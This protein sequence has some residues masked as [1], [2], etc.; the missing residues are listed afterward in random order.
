MKLVIATKN[1]NKIAEIQDKF[2]GIPGLEMIPLT[3]FPDPP[4]VAEDGATFAENAI[5]K[6]LAAA[7][8]T[9]HAAMADDSGLV[10]DALDG[11]PGVL[12]ARYGGEGA[13]DAER[14]RKILVEMAEIQEGER[15][16]RF[17]CVIAIAFPGGVAW[18]AE[19]VCEGM[20]ARRMR[21]EHGFGYDPIFYLPDRGRTM[22]E[23]P[24]DEK[25]RISHRARALDAAREFLSRRSDS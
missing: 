12:S 2:S 18:S 1:R 24:L 11:R 14:N 15:G 22:A 6:A 19:G 8:H 25:N 13:T 3:D 9:G 16:A 10:I 21:G 7:G 23:L 5:K 20:I 4:D 17:V